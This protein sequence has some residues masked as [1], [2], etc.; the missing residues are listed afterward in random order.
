MR[1]APMASSRIALERIQRGRIAPHWM[2]L[3]TGAIAGIMDLGK[4]LRV[5]TRRAKRFPVA[6]RE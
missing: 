1:R 5:A 6:S 3:R 4:V 2:T